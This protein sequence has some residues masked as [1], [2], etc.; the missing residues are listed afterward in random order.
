MG[1][2]VACLRTWPLNQQGPFRDK[3]LTVWLLLPIARQLGK[4]TPFTWCDWC[5]CFNL[6]KLGPV[7]VAEKDGTGHSQSS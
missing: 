1:A 7:S 6:P 4:I 2:E 5:Q 3:G